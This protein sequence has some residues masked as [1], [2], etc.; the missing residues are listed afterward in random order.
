MSV[1]G[2]EKVRDR[3]QGLAPMRFAGLRSH[4]GP[5]ER[6]EKL[7]KLLDVQFFDPD[8]EI[9]EFFGAS[10]ERLEKEFL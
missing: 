1:L 10:V 7:A 8:H 2:R 9:G 5:W 3:V 6:R 4:G